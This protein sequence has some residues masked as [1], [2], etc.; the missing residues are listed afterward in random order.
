ML[1]NTIRTKIIEYALGFALVAIPFTFMWGYFTG[2]SAGMSHAD[3][4]TA[5]NQ[6]ELAQ[7]NLQA[8]QAQSTQSNAAGERLATT[9]QAVQVRT[10]TL[11]KEVYK[12][13]KVHPISNDCR[14]GSERVRL[15]NDANTAHSAVDSP[16]S[17]T[18][19]RNAAVP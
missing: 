14:I 11:I 10:Q 12:N 19:E 4:A 2:K 6:T 16:S 8:V 13:E 1:D 15:W 5:Q 9:E 7:S 18:A 3:L 17:I